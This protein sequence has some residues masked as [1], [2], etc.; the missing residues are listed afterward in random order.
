LG[1]P[2]DTR[3]RRDEPDAFTA[4]LSDPNAAPHGGE[5]VADLVLRVGSWVA[6][7]RRASAA[8]IDVTQSAVIRAAIISAIEATGATFWHLDVGPLAQAWLRTDGRCWTLREL[9]Q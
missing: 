6:E 9:R 2:A 3:R 7:C 5:S 1:W 8:T 4:W